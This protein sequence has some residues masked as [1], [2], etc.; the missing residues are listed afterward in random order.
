MLY[1]I[2]LFGVFVALGCDDKPEPLSEGANSQQSI[3]ADPPSGAPQTNHQ[4]Q[5][6]SEHD[7]AIRYF[8]SRTYRP[9]D[10][11]NEIRYYADRIEEVPSKGVIYIQGRARWIQEEFFLI[12][13]YEDHESM[14]I[15]DKQTLQ[16]IHKEGEFQESYLLQ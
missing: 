14:M 11:S 9:T 7:K 2:L 6:E 8:R 3:T 16:I 13:G 10:R 5:S 1:G 12:D 4:E 15:L